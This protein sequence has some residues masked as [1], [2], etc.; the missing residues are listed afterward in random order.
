MANETKAMLT[1]MALVSQNAKT[2]SD[3]VYQVIIYSHMCQDLLRSVQQR[4]QMLD[5]YSYTYMYP[6]C[7][8]LLTVLQC[9][10]PS[11]RRPELNCLMLDSSKWLK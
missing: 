8:K 5:G 9:S 2:R 3:V 6:L 11:N 4:I 10:L 1:Y 7:H